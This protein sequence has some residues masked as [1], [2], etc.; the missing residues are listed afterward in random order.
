MYQVGKISQNNIKGMIKVLSNKLKIPSVIVY[1]ENRKEYYYK[2]MFMSSAEKI[3]GTAL[4][5]F[6]KTNSLNKKY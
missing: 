2:F 5:S 4:D 3:S 6:V 1:D